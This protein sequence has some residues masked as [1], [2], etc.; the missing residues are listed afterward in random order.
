MP[1]TTITNANAGSGANT[2]TTPCSGRADWVVA[3]SD[4]T[5]TAATTAFQ[6]AP[7][8]Y[9]G[10]ASNLIR[11]GPNVTR[12]YLR[13]RFTSATT[14]AVS[15]TVKVYGVKGASLETATD[16]WRIDDEDGSAAGFTFGGVEATPSATN[17]L[18]ITVGGVT[19]YLSDIAGQADD[20]YDCL[21]ADFLIVLVSV[22]ATATNGA[23][24]VQVGFLN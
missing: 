20:G 4:A 7:L 11:V 8:T 19:Y 17:M 9:T 13:A 21:G 22:A 16:I 15:P 2:V 14:A 1:L 3:V 24:D 12:C 6:F 5:A 23:C 18:N 10:T